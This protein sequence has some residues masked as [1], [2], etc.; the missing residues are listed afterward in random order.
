MYQADIWPQSSLPRQRVR[1]VAVL[2]LHDL[3][4]TLLGLPRLAGIAVEVNDVMARLVAVPVFADEALDSRLLCL[5]RE[6]EQFIEFLGEA[7]PCP[8]KRAI[9]PGTS[10]G[11]YQEYCQ[12]V[13]SVMSSPSLMRIERRPP[14]ALRILAAHQTDRGIEEVLETA[15]TLHEVRVIVRL[16]QGLGHLGDALV[17]EGVFERL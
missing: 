13:P 14:L 3:V 8:P 16:A 2:R 15:R 9:K 17:V 7:S 6:G 12:L 11:A 4:Q 1:L 5:V 10:C